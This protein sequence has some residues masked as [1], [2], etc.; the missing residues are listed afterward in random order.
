MEK[1]IKLV[2]FDLD[3]TLIEVGDNHVHPVVQNAIR[4]VV[5]K[6]VW[7]TLATG[8]S[9]VFTQ[10]I[11]ADLNLTAPLMC[12][13]GGVIQA[14]DGRVLRTVKLAADVIW[15]ALDL[16]RGRDLQVYFERDGELILQRDY[17]YDQELIDI[18]LLPVQWVTDLAQVP[19][20]NQL[21]IYLPNGGTDSLVADLQVAFGSAAQVMRTH[22]QFINAAAASKGKALAWLAEQLGVAQSEV[23]AVGDSDNDVSMVEWAGAGVAMGDARPAVLEVADWVAPSLAEHG[24]AV[25][26]AHFGLWDDGVSRDG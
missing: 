14:M 4:Q 10:Q 8:R 25:A 24:A 21:G 13:Q 19:D 18:Q 11:A 23:M 15:P 17:H 5:A 9:F 2:A 3:G 16:A 26:L 7:V 20:A 22:R 6:G 12:H 1:T